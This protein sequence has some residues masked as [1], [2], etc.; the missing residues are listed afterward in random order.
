[1]EKKKLKRPARGESEGEEDRVEKEMRGD[2]LVKGGRSRGCRRWVKE[3][4]WQG[5][6]GFV[7]G[8]QQQRTPGDDDFV[9]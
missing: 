8:E 4:K 7:L 1:L 6:L 2:G 3:K 9:S 5:V